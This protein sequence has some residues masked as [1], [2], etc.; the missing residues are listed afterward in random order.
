MT[1]LGGRWD[2]DFVNKRVFRIAGVQ[3]GVVDSA[4]S[5]YSA[6]QDEFDEPGQM[7]DQVPMSAQTPTEFSVINQWFI[8]DVSIQSL[9]GGA[10]Q[11]VGWLVGVT[12]NII[13]IEYSSNDYRR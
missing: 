4:V 1:I 7:D 10:L 13:Q 5:L 2:I 8:D 3:T 9:N 12:R 11:S 6:V